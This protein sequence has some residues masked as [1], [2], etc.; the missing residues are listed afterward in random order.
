MGVA[1]RHPHW[2]GQATPCLLFFLFFFFFF[3]K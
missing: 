3:K 1:A 2:L